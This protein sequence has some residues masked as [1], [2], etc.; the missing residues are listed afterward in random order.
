M[1]V[2]TQPFVFAPDTFVQALSTDLLRM[3]PELASA[4][5]GVF[6]RPLGRVLQGTLLMRGETSLTGDFIRVVL[7][8]GAGRLVNGWVATP[9]VAA[10]PPRAATLASPGSIP[11]EDAAMPLSPPP[12]GTR[13]AYEDHMA[14]RS[15]GGTSTGS[16]LSDA[17]DVVTSDTFFTILGTALTAGSYGYVTG[18]LDITG[19]QRLIVEE[20]MKAIA[21]GLARVAQ[22]YAACRAAGRSDCKVVVPGFFEAWQGQ[23][24][25][26]TK[27]MV[28]IGGPAFA[29][30]V[31]NIGSALLTPVSQTA[32]KS[33]WDFAKQTDAYRRDP[34]TAAR[35]F[36]EEQ[37]AR[38]TPGGVLGGVIGAPVTPAPAPMGLRDFCR[39]DMIAQATNLAAGANVFDTAEW[40]PGTGE[41]P[42]PVTTNLSVADA[43]ARFFEVVRAAGSA[44]T[45]E[46]A[47]ALEVVRA[48]ERAQ[49]QRE[50][51]A[52]SKR[53]RAARAARVTNPDGT[54]TVPLAN[55]GVLIVDPRQPAPTFGDLYPELYGTSPRR[56]LV[57]G[58]FT[59]S[60]IAAPAFAAVFILRQLAGR[61]TT[62]SQARSRGGRR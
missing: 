48:A 24:A 4:G 10:I 25:W 1:N 46:G 28:E 20:G 35:R 43:R 60:L 22:D 61:R 41:P 40:D 19:A 37:T 31:A 59:A 34:E 2:P 47:R 16:F 26:R 33:A 9:T 58:L 30:R 52:A 49:A 12:P 32:L 18:L 36:L 6:E 3:N 29:A 56:N 13:C 5:P 39:K 55:G 42:P 62:G 17:F 38:C 51:D 44:D 11:G 7:L 57:R 50:L 8:D 54:V 45:P 15:S 21:G 23:V 27:R 14:A 53:D